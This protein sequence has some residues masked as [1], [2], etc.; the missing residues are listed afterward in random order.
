MKKIMI[1]SLCCLVAAGCRVETSEVVEQKTRAR[2]NLV[3]NIDGRPQPKK[4]EKPWELLELPAPGEFL[5]QT[6][7]PIVIDTRDFAK[8]IDPSAVDLTSEPNEKSQ[9][10]EA[11]IVIAPRGR[12][13]GSEQVDGRSVVTPKGIVTSTFTGIRNNSR[14]MDPTLAV[15][16]FHI[17]HAVNEEFA[18]F[19]KN[20]V[21]T[22]Q[23]QFTD[24]FSEFVDPRISDPKCV[25]DHYSNRFVMSI[26]GFSMDDAGNGFSNIYLAISDDDDPNG[27]WFCYVI[28][29]SFCLLYTSPSPRDATLSR[30]PSS[31]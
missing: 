30:M 29:S 22:F 9:G 14:P 1:L 17:I 20:G 28:P 26:L 5:R 12:K 3:E 15:G 24:F 31:A 6:L 16:P 25:Y 2:P 10:N 21:L 23:Q 8:Q 7:V 18:F 4:P 13:S 27:I 11:S 19:T